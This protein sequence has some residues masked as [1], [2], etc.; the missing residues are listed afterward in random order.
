[1]SPRKKKVEVV[2]EKPKKVD[3]IVKKNDINIEDVI[4]FFKK[5][6]E[7]LIKEQYYSR[8]SFFL[9]FDFRIKK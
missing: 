2:E 4:D 6:P 3:S 9:D 7:Y 5:N 8:Y 1:M